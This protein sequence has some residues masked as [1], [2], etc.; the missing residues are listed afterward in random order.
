MVFDVGGWALSVGSLIMTVSLD[1]TGKCDISAQIIFFVEETRFILMYAGG[2]F[3]NIGI[4][5]KGLIYY[6][7][8]CAV[9]VA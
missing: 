4:A 6:T 8:R 1:I 2:I 5:S 7:V 9:P 3:V